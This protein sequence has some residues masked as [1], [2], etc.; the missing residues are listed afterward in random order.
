MRALAFLPT[1]ELLF[2]RLVLVYQM[3][4]IGSQTIETTLH[5]CSFPYPIRRFHFLSSALNQTVRRGVSSAGPDPVWKRDARLQLSDVRE[6]SRTLRLRRLFCACGAAIPRLEVITGVRELISLVLSSVFE[7]YLYFEPAVAAMTVPRCR[8]ILLHPKTF[9]NLR[10]WFDLELKRFL[11]I[12]VFETPFDTDQGYCI[13]QNRFARVLVYR[14]E[15]L[16]SLPTLLQKFLAWDVP[17]LVN[18]NIGAEKAYAERY[19]EV[20][21]K[22]RLPKEFVRSLYEGHMMRHFYSASERERFYLKWAETPVMT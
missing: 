7:N 5:H 11:G 1:R 18:C 20:S 9:L 16:R 8:D 14:F 21:Q 10:N 13:H 6:I 12:D 22:L 4:K 2:S 3:P 19:R 17:S 15:A